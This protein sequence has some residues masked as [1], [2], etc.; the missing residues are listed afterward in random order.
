MFKAVLLRDASAKKVAF[1]WHYAQ[2][3][4]GQTCNREDKQR[5]KQLSENVMQ[6]NKPWGLCTVNSAAN[7]RGF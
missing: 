1:R 6:L 2:S 5:N 7:R 3:T 4:Q